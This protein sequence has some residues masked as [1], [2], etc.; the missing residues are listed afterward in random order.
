MN[1]Y[2]KNGRPLQVPGD[3]VYS[4]S[5][6][7]VGR[8]VGEKVHGTDG[9]YVGTIVGDVLVYRSTESANVSGS[10]SAG[11]RGGS[12]TADRAGS[13]IWGDEPDIPD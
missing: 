4:G 1:L 2:T 3:R 8:I 12:A 13:A 11:D 10:F 9:Q 5:G 6:T 7:I